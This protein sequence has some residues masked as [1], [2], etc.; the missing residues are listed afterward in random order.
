MKEFNVVITPISGERLI[1]SN[2]DAAVLFSRA[3]E[4]FYKIPAG[5]PVSKT[6][7]IYDY[8]SEYVYE[9]LKIAIETYKKESRHTIY[10]QKQKQKRDI[11]ILKSMLKDAYDSEKEKITSDDLH[12]KIKKILNDSST[13]DHQ[14]SHKYTLIP[15]SVCSEKVA[16]YIK[17]LFND[18]HNKF[19]TI[20][21]IDWENRKVN[22]F[23]ENNG[24][25]DMYQYDLD[26]EVIYFACVND[27]SN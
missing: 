22:V 1:F 3:V 27:S 18:R 23:V 24:Y 14:K 6:Y 2:T 26:D 4:K 20:D 17:F 11:Q 5:V 13:G 16:K 21:K 10:P 15:C 7:R 12:N 9:E 25:I 19:Y 8:L